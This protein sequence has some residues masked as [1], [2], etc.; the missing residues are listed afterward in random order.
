MNRTCL[1]AAGLLI[2]AGAARA[3]DSDSVGV[4]PHLF[5][6]TPASFLAISGRVQLAFDDTLIGAIS[7]PTKTDSEE[8]VTY[9]KGASI[10]PESV[11]IALGFHRP[12]FSGFI[13]HRIANGY[14]TL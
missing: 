12:N 3:N 14:T 5:T 13:S 6:L 1:V 10:Q 4:D 8:L 9:I 11:A 7:I 2:I